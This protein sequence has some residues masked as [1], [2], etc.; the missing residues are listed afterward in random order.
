MTNTEGAPAISTDTKENRMALYTGAAYFTIAGQDAPLLTGSG[1]QR[2][3]ETAAIL[4][5]ERIR[6]DAIGAVVGDMTASIAE[7]TADGTNVL[8]SVTGTVGTV[9]V[10]LRE[11]LDALDS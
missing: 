8:F 9:L 2:D 11:H 3:H 4:L 6:T 10:A 5:D 7:D 1:L